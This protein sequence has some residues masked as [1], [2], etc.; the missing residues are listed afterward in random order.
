MNRPAGTTGYG[1]AAARL[2]EQY[3]AVDFADVH[4]DLRPH[5]PAPPAAVL[6]VGAGTGRDAAALARL[7]HRV[8]AAEP[9]PELRAIGERLHA[10]A[11]IRWVPDALP[12]LP[13]LRAETAR[14]DLVLLT[15]VWMHL[16]PEERPAAMDALAALLAPGGRLSLTLR[17]GPVPADR[18][19][20]DAGAEEA[21]DLA[22]ARGLRLRHRAERADQCTGGRTC[23]GR[24]CS[25]N[26][27]GSGRGT[28]PG[29]GPA[30]SLRERPPPPHLQQGPA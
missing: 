26:G 22:A 8:T 28:E 4:R 30:A 17:H 16:A 2:A 21:V 10:G 1:P 19:M 9:T 13:L 3:E 11:G 15:A 5:Y 24:C 25:S 27:P 20:Y 7:G 12:E 14:Y 23:T 18:R 6:D 29:G